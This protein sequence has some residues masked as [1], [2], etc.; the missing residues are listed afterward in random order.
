MWGEPCLVDPG[1]GVYASDPAWR[2]HFRGTAAHSTVTVDAAGQA[3][4]TGP[5]AW[6]DLPRARLRR[7]IS[8]DRFD[9]ADAEHDAYRRLPD[10]VTHRRRVLFVR[11]RYWVVVDDLVGREEHR[12]EARFQFAPLHVAERPDGWVSAVDSR[13]RGMFLRA[14]GGARLGQRI[15]EGS[16]EPRQGWVSPDYGKCRPSPVLILSAS[17]RLPLR[18]L[19]LLVPKAREADAPPEV[20][21]WRREGE[22]P[23]GLIFGPNE[24]TVVFEEDGVRF[25][26]PPT[27]SALTP[28][29]PVDGRPSRPGTSSTTGV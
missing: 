10:P 2:D 1:T 22:R 24:E 15:V 20:S 29:S 7:W 26:P 23:E 6:R 13:G 9:L 27:I 14:F 21:V 8:N 17:A 4:A 19:T 12:I 16:I 5:F 25:D 18:I 11:P 28:I 3:V